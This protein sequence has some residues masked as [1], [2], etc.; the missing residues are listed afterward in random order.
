MLERSVAPVR[1][2]GPAVE[3]EHANAVQCLHRPEAG[4][5][6]L[7]PGSDVTDHSKPVLPMQGAHC[8]GPGAGLIDAPRRKAVRV[9]ARLHEIAHVVV[10][11]DEQNAF[12]GL[13]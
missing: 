1:G 3:F 2:A 8:R 12:S 5:K 10:A 7:L 11:V 4:G 6:R 13:G 9:E